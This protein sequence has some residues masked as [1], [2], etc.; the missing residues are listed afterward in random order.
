MRTVFQQYYN[1][2]WNTR[3][4][5]Y[6]GKGIEFS[7]NNDNNNYTSFI[8][9]KVHSITNSVGSSGTPYEGIQVGIVTPPLGNEG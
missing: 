4:T 1:N 3:Q 8:A 9:G 6:Y 7:D 5:R 2:I